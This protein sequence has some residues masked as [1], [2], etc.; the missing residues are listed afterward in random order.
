M[1]KNAYFT[2]FKSME[3][4]VHKASNVIYYYVELA[5]PPEDPVGTEPDPPKP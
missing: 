2:T 4:D 5:K 1:K 3:R